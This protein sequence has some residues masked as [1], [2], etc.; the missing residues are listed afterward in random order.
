MDSVVFYKPPSQTGSSQTKFIPPCSTHASSLHKRSPGPRPSIEWLQDH[1]EWIPSS[2]P[3]VW[4]LSPV[5][6]SGLVD[7]L[8]PSISV[9]RPRPDR[10]TRI[11]GTLAS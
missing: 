1:V 7:G 3:D 10:L 2:E 8:R 4:I 11:G 6:D 9:L 5:P